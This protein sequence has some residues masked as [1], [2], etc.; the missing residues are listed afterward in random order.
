MRNEIVVVRYVAEKK[1]TAY[2]IYEEGTDW[3]LTVTRANSDSTFEHRPGVKF[4]SPDDVYPALA[5][6][7]DE[8]LAA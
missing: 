1:I 4:D 5:K 6:M 7:L 2:A 3:D 8:V